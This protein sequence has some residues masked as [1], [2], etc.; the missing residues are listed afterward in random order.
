MVKYF[1]LALT[2]SAQHNA[3]VHDELKNGTEKKF[4]SLL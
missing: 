2:L 4:F 1:M 3:F